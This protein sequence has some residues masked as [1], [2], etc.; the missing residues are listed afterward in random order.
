MSN[1][2]FFTHDNTFLP[3]TDF[4]Q[5]L[6][7]INLILTLILKYF[8]FFN[9]GISCLEHLFKL[10]FVWKICSMNMSPRKV[11]RNISCVRVKLTAWQNSANT[12]VISNHA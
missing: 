4:A 8:I 11:I 3:T 9:V 12:N 2:V 7:K 10:E 5:Q 6:P 1:A